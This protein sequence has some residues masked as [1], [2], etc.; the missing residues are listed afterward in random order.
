MDSAPERKHRSWLANAVANISDEGSQDKFWARHGFETLADY[1]EYMERSWDDVPWAQETP[2]VGDVQPPSLP[3]ESAADV[4][5]ELD[6][7]RRSKQVGMRL[8]PDDYDVLADAARVHG[9]APS[10]LARILTVA[11]ARALLSRTRSGSGA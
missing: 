7:R 5:S 1:I 6:S 3:P 8:T 10:T 2:D 11:G 9:V 4:R